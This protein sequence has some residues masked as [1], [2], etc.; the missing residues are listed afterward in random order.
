MRYNMEWG[1]EILKKALKEV[2]KYVDNELLESC[3]IFMKMYENQ[4]REMGR[5]FGPEEA[6]RQVAKKF[7]ELFFYSGERKRPRI[8]RLR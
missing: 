7:Y 2:L 5:I 8:Q 1:D 3:K 6:A 4:W